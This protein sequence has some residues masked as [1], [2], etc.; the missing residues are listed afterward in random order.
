MAAPGVAVSA[1]VGMGLERIVAIRE[2]SGLRVVVVAAMLL[3]VLCSPIAADNS[4]TKVVALKE[5]IPITSNEPQCFCYKSTVD[6]K[7]HHSWTKIQIQV[8]S[9]KM[10]RMTQVDSEEKL[11][12]LKQITIWGILSSFLKEKLNDTYINVDLYSKETCLKVDIIEPKT[13]YTVTCS[14]AFDLK[15]FLVFTT[16]ALLFFCAETLSRSQVF[17]YSTGMSVGI[18]ASSLILLFMLSKLMPKKSPFYVL[19]VGG[20][21]FSLYVIQLVFKNLQRIFKGYWQ[22]LLGYVSLMGILSFAVCYRYGPLENERSINLLYWA[23]QLIGLLLMY[24]GIQVRQAALTLILI[25]FCTKYIEYPVLWT[26]RAYRFAD[27]V[28]GA[29]H[30][31]P[32]EHLTHEQE[33][34][35]GGSFVEDQL[36][37]DLEDSDEREEL[38]SYTHPNNHV[39]F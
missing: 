34:G 36:Y 9:N 37:E 5:G 6:P 31:T 3:F 15:L 32:N 29:S 30:L 7:W 22:Y 33:Y 1:S 11:E 35:L 19:L 18:L 20:W 14:R 24:A 23:L 38:Q 28:E 4:Q 25:A 27:F 13:A 16:G 8:S 2:A 39:T 17:Y 10:I 12:E 21:S 26:Y